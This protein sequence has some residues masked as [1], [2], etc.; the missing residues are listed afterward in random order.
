MKHLKTKNGFMVDT[1]ETMPT[2]GLIL[3]VPITHWSDHEK[4]DIEYY[5]SKDNGITYVKTYKSKIFENSM[6][7]LAAAER[8]KKSYTEYLL[9][10]Y[11]KSRDKLKNLH[12]N[13]DNV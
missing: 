5:F 3:E 13:I 12:I 6:Q 4:I 2:A 8:E 9:K 10:E 7:A 1:W 11:K